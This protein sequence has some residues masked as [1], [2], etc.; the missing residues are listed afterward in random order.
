MVGIAPDAF[1]LPIKVLSDSGSGSSATLYNGAKWAVDNYVRPV[2][3]SPTNQTVFNMSLGG[4]SA[5]GL[6]SLQLIRNSGSISVVAAGNEGKSS[7][8][9]PARYATDSSVAGWVLVVG[10]VDSANNMP[11]WSNR[12]G[13]T[14]NYYLVAPGVSITSTSGTADYTSMSGTSMATP[15][16]SGAAA[17]VW[18]AWPYLKGNQVVDSLLLSATDLGAAGVDATFGRG[19]LNLAAAMQPIGSH[20]IVQKIGDCGTTDYIG[21]SPPPDDNQSG[22]GTGET[23]PAPTTTK[24]GKGAGKTKT[25]M[26]STPTAAGNAVL[27]TTARVVGYDSIGRDFSFSALELLRPSAPSMANSM[28]SLLTNSQPVTTAVKRGLNSLSYQGNLTTGITSFSFTQVAANSGYLMGFKGNGLIPF[29]VSH[30]DFHA[31]AF[32][33]SDALKIPFL[34]LMESPTGVAY[35]RS[36]AN[37]IGVRFGYLAGNAAANPVTVDFDQPMAVSSNGSSLGELSAHIGRLQVVGTLGKLNEDGAFLGAVS[38]GVQAKGET[39]FLSLAAVYPLGNGLKALA[40]A[41]TGKTE[42]AFNAGSVA[43]YDTTT[44]AYSVG[45][46]KKSFFTEMDQLSFSATLPS[47]VVSGGISLVAGVDVDRLTGAPLIGIVPVSLTPSG[48]E[49][50]FE[51]SWMSPTKTGSIGLTAM[52]RVEPNHDASAKSENAFGLRLAHTF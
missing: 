18:G 1:I 10:A 36:F 5:F 43:S 29:G 41:T 30:S 21:T 13:S 24:P 14:R 44:R 51:L 47:R 25:R 8:S 9:Y 19:L 33:G 52:H 23:E 48:H 22:G 35:G 28:N 4:S 40:S 32:V 27:L 17:V 37:G 45:L 39:K 15:V 38:S 46:L 12:A 2:S 6:D 50:R 7:P 49:R 20:C 3:G 42:G 16:V 31:N 26:V 34:G 11:S